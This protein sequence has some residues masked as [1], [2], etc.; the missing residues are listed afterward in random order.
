MWNIASFA[1]DIA[2]NRQK[3]AE[4]FQENRS[5]FLGRIVSA[6]SISQH[7]QDATFETFCGL[8]GLLG[9]EAPRQTFGISDVFGAAGPN[10]VVGW[11]GFLK[12]ASQHNC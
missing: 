8:F 7:F 5:D 1:A 11:G 2:E 12:L 3:D 4:K 9:P 6:F 10:D